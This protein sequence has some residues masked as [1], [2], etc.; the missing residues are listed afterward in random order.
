MTATDLRYI[1]G[2]CTCVGALI[3][4]W[5]VSNWRHLLSYLMAYVFCLLLFAAGLWVMGFG[6]SRIWGL[7]TCVSAIYSFTTFPRDSS[8]GALVMGYFL[9]LL[10]FSSGVFVA[11]R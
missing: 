6:P 1:P 11:S 8:P 4:L 7:V 10:M 5:R 9:C 3:L 2:I